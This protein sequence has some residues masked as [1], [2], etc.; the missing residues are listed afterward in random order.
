MKAKFYIGIFSALL[1]AASPVKAQF[2]D[3][4]DYR[5][6]GAGIVIN[7]YYDDYDY[8]FSS[9]INRFHRS[10]AAF[11][12]YS[13][14]FTDTY[15][16]NY[17]PY[18]WGLSIYGRSGFGYGYSVNYPV[19]YNAWD[20]NRGYDPYYGSSYYW[21]YDPFYYSWYSPVIININIGSRWRNN[22]WGWNSHNHWYNDYRPVYN[23]YNHNHIYHATRYSS[24]E[25]YNDNKSSG[26]NRTSS[27]YNRNSSGAAA[28]RESKGAP[29]SGT[30]VNRNNERMQSGN[31]TGQER[32][33][34]GA[35]NTGTYNRNTGN[36]SNTGN[37][38]NNRNSRTDGNNGNFGQ[39]DSNIGNSGNNRNSNSDGN[40]GNI[41]N[42]RST[43]TRPPAPANV[44]SRSDV[45]TKPASSSS[46]RTTK[47]STGSRSSS[48]RSFRAPEPSSSPSGS[49]GTRVSQGRSS[50]SGSVAKTS[51]PSKSSGS[52]SETSSSSS[53]KKDRSRR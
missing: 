3:N 35:R 22:Y 36:S 52:S 1:L 15:W 25:Y 24:R 4:R 33:S 51:G 42:T 31:T 46:E 32:R 19:Y 37:N 13:P 21:G 26:Y 23:T 20:Y 17:Q 49:G 9:R 27:G 38:G 16:Y 45:T 6:D 47:V 50:S 30:D 53:N 12:Y 40:K 7:N 29:T 48:E 11:E 28:R 39:N 2:A 44:P 5:N 43:V 10:Y 41:T 34:A 8:Y 18:S 14:V